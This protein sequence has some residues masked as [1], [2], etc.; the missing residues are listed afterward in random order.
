MP[1][2]AE[3]QEPVA[4]ILAKPLCVKL[5][6]HGAEPQQ[7]GGHV[8]PVAS[9]Q[10]EEGREEGAAAGTGAACDEAHELADLERDEGDAEESG[11]KEGELG[12]L[13]IPLTDRKAPHP[14]GKGR[15]EE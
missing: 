14:A 15:G 6:H 11:G 5:R 13:L 9:H 7:A 8:Y 12:P 10:G 3:A 4:N 2:E 1:E